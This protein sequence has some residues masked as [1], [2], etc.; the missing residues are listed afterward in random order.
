MIREA[1]VNDI[2]TLFEMSLKFLKEGGIFDHIPLNKQSLSD[3]IATL[4]LADNSTILV[5]DEGGIKGAVAGTISP[6]FINKDILVSNEFAWWVFPE[7]RGKVGKPLLTGF[8]IWSK[9]NGADLVVMM[10]LEKLNPKLV[11]KVYKKENYI[12]TEHSYIKE[13]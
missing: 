7:Y 3:W 9:T 13:L 5:Y 4:I 6:H 12:L 2:D 11:D 1:T 8:E 10:S